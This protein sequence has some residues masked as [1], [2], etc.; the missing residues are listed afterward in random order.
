MKRNDL[1][2]ELLVISCQR[3]DESAFRELVNRWE[4]RLYYYLRRVIERESR[5]WDALQ[6]TWLA[7]FQNIRRLEN[8]AMFP[9]WLY[10]ICHSKAVDLLR[11]EGRYVQMAE[12]PTV[13]TY[14]GDLSP[15]LA[16][17]QAELVHELLARL[18]L[19]HR[20]V[21]T[22]RFLEGFSIGE[23]AQILGVSEGTVKSRLHYAKNKLQEKLER[24]NNV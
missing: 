9:T 12:E 15:S 8:P 18:K 1:P 19:P 6:E 23:M 17:E 11:K 2:D 10:R 14:E 4:P 21:L 5:V 7:V 16:K 20:E 22:L 24:A 3:R 13:G